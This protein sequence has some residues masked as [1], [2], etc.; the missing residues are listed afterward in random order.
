M[1]RTIISAIKI[2]HSMPKS[3]ENIFSRVYAINLRTR[4]DRSNQ[5]HKGLKNTTGPSGGPKSGKESLPAAGRFPVQQASQK[6]E[7]HLAADNRMWE[8]CSDA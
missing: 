5:F 7:A 6:V 3:L 1:S 2:L 8:S 4:P